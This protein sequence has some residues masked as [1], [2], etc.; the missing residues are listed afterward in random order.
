MPMKRSSQ[1]LLASC[2]VGHKTIPQ[3][4]HNICP[5]VP[6]YETTR[7]SWSNSSDWLQIPGNTEE[8]EGLSVCQL[9]LALCMWLRGCDI[10]SISWSICVEE[11]VGTPR[12]ANMELNY[13]PDIWTF[14]EFH[15]MSS[16]SWTALGTKKLKELQLMAFQLTPLK[17]KPNEPQFHL[18]L[19]YLTPLGPF[20][21]FPSKGNDFCST[22]TTKSVL[23]RFCNWFSK[24]CLHP[25][26]LLDRRCSLYG[27]PT[28]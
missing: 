22:E 24:R 2:I 16:G 10:C 15:H 20:F 26:H 23:A 28:G 13:F 8:I 17:H 12:K 18:S 11:V 5:L 1:S 27:P 7:W 19:S 4:C 3:F 25:S 21:R 14:D 9:F 6:S